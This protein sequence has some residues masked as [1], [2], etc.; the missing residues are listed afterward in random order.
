MELSALIDWVE[1]DSNQRKGEI[2]LIVEG[3]MAAVKDN[4]QV[5][6]YL[7]ILLAE[8]PVKQSV[9]LVVKLTGEHKNEVYKRALELKQG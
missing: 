4:T 1:A 7:S 9:S 6:H 5:D 8:L 2:V 3:D